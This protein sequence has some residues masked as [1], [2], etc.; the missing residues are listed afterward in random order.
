MFVVSDRTGAIGLPRDDRRSVMTAADAAGVETHVEHDRVSATT[1]VDAATVWSSR[2]ATARR[3]PGPSS[4]GGWSSHG[5]GAVHAGEVDVAERYSY[6]LG[7]SK[8]TVR[9]WETGHRVIEQDALAHDRDRST[10][11]TGLIIGVG[12]HGVVASREPLGGVA[13]GL[14]VPAAGS[15]DEG[16]SGDRDGDGSE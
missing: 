10:A 6:S 9:V 12:F 1:V 14:L 3:R 15:A 4:P 5:G 7:S 16:E 11:A 8:L 13:A 2:S